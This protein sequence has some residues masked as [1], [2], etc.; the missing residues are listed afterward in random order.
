MRIS[1]TIII[2]YIY[3]CC[4]IMYYVVLLCIMHKI[5]IHDRNIRAQ[6]YIYNNNNTIHSSSKTKNIVT[7]ENL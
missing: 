5:L 1:V 3:L 7:K 4:I 6:L 2:Y